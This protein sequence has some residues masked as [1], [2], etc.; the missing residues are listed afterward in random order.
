M[1]EILLQN[2]N[3]VILGLIQG[4]TEF[5]P[6]SSSGH[7]V[8]VRDFLGMVGTNDLAY[9][10]VLQLA[11]LVSVILYFSG[12]IIRMIFKDQKQ[13]LY[14]VIA[15]IPAVIF[16]MTLET[17]MEGVFRGLSLVVLTLVMGSV[18]MWFAE[19]MYA[20]RDTDIKK[21][22]TWPTA[23]WIGFFQ[24]LALVPGMS[25]SGMTISG[26]LF[27]GLD[28]EMATRFSFL[29]SIPIILGSGGKK[30]LE[31]YQMGNLGL[32]TPLLVGSITAFI[33][34]L[35]AIHFLLKF[36]RSHTLNL[37][38]WYRILLAIGIVGYLVYGAY[39]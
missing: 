18:V 14:L 28:R 39:F 33:T 1:Q 24:V 38:V 17:Y 8:I 3:Y 26:G 9:D 31:I 10:A 32:N 34:G 22:M 6:I 7:L 11:T 5:L 12:D 2:I 21:E 13:L 19:R 16:G 15:T 4:L 36:L 27:V 35:V 29:L 25:R 37:F 23:L 30:M 20:E